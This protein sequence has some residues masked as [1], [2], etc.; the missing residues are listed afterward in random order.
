MSNLPKIRPCPFCEDGGDPHVFHN[1]VMTV[2]RVCCWLCDGRGPTDKSASLAIQMWNV[3]PEERRLALERAP[4]TDDDINK[5]LARCHEAGWYADDDRFKAA[6]TGGPES[7]PNLAKRRER[8]I[9]PYY[10]LSWIQAGVLDYLPVCRYCDEIT[11]IN[12]DG[13]LDCHECGRQYG[14]K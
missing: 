6:H 9:R 3:R 2:W 10:E 13:N 14:T 5:M 7:D 4:I 1:Q 11:I 8:D 12:K